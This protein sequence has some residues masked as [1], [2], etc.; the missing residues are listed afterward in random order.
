[1]KRLVPGPYT[2]ILE[3]TREVPKVLRMKRKTVGIR[4]PAHPVA[5]ALVQELG[6]P[7]VSTSASLHNE[8][9]IDP[10]EIDESY[11][12]LDLVIDADTGG[13]R[14]STIIDLSGPEPVIVREGAGPVDFL[15]G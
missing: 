13:I 2:F 3:A 8:Y 11:S 6:R 10:V 12:Q 9:L 7:I 4:V 15:V 5:L 14:A 1:M